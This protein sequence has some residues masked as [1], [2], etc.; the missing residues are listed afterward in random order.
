VQGIDDEV[1]GL[2]RAAEGQMQFSGV[3]VHNT[4]GRVLLP[5]SHVVVN[6]LVVA[7][8]VLAD[9]HRGLAVHAQS[10]DRTAFA[11]LVLVLDVGEDRIGFWDFFWG[12]ALSTGRSR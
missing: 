3:F 12:L 6:G 1:T 9:V 10:H 5:A 7:A 2:R 4:E 8:G 11:G